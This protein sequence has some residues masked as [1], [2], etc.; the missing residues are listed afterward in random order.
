MERAGA[1]ARPPELGS[2]AR[3]SVAGAWAR[4]PKPG[5][6]ARHPVAEAW[7]GPYQGGFGSQGFGDRGMGGPYQG[8]LRRQ[9]GGGRGGPGGFGGG[10]T[11]Y[12]ARHYP[13]EP[14]EQFQQPRRERTSGEVLDEGWG[15]R[16]RAEPG[17]TDGPLDYGFGEDHHGGHGHGY[18]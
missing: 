9:G 8:R 13:P 14:V 2:D 7:A 5:S 6:D 4:P 16:R 12:G 10:G 1:G 11:D 18:W 3:D 15:E 17:P